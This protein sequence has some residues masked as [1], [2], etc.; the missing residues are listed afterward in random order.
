MGPEI[1][2]RHKN[3]ASALAAKVVF[4]LRTGEFDHFAA[5]QHMAG[6]LAR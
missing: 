6:I 2:H 1:R 4:R 3:K 5:L